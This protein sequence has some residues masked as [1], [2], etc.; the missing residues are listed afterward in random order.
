MYMY[1][2]LIEDP[3]AFY[4]EAKLTNVWTDDEKKI[5]REKCVLVIFCLSLCS[6][7]G[8]FVCFSYHNCFYSEEYSSLSLS[9]PLSLSPS[10]SLSLSLSLPQICP[11]PKEFPGYCFVS[12]QQGTSDHYTAVLSVMYF[13]WHRVA[14]SASSITTC[15]RRTKTSSSFHGK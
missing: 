10:L 15:Q 11:L 12:S 6:F 14:Q 2:G 1:V 3:M 13:V 8:L 9:L 5:F 7:V 4:R